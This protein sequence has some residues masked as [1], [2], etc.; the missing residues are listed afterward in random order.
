MNEG[1]QNVMLPIL[2][3]TKKVNLIIKYDEKDK[4]GRGGV[5]LFK[6]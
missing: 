6:L 3:S 4:V 5:E 1:H 2:S